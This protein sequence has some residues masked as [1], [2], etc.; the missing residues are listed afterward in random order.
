MPEKVSLL[1]HM[2]LHKKGGMSNMNYIVGLHIYL[3]IWSQLS[4]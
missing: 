3:L 4:L 1:S 2:V